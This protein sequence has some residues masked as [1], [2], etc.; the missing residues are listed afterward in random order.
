MKVSNAG[1]VFISRANPAVEAL[2]LGTSNGSS[3]QIQ[4]VCINT[5]PQRPAEPI[6]S[7]VLAA[8]GFFVVLMNSN[9]PTNPYQGQIVK[10]PLFPP[11]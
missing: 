7:K 5:P 9:S 4:M 2:A 11:F 10:K 8:Q 6:F 1:L 3:C